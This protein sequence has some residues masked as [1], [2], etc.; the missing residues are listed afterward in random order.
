MNK[1]YVLIVLY[2]KKYLEVSSHVT[3]GVSNNFVLVH[4]IAVPPLN[5][6]SFQT[7]FKQQMSGPIMYLL[8]DTS[9]VNMPCDLRL[10]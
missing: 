6:N 8:S 4:S 5:V 9:L 10:T 3:R 1:G 7:V 2:S